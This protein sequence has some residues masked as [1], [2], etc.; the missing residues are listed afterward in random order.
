[1]RSG[2]LDNNNF[3]DSSP[4]AGGGE[5]GVCQAGSGTCLFLREPCEEGTIIDPT[6]YPMRELRVRELPGLPGRNSGASPVAL[7]SWLPEPWLQ[8]CPCHVP[9]CSVGIRRPPHRCV[10]TERGRSCGW[11][12]RCS[13][14]TE[15]SPVLKNWIPTSVHQLR[16]QGIVH[17]LCASVSPPGQATGP[18]SWDS[19]SSSGERIQHSAWQERAGF[20][21]P[22]VSVRRQ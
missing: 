12:G 20:L 9:A 13:Q 19:V 17:P 16:A 22:G 4:A 1:M 3:N 15:S 6:F 10:G 14:G 11:G 21:R 5:L 8:A 18:T 2:R 7:P